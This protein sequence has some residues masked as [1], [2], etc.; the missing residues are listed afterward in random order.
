M[1]RS[2]FPLPS[3]SHLRTQI[4]N[5][6]IVIGG[7]GV[8]SVETYTCPVHRFKRNAG[9]IR[10]MMKLFFF[11]SLLNVA[12]PFVGGGSGSPCIQ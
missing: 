5:Y 2:Q 12:M 1:P 3:T 8:I 4:L 7:F 6:V 10:R 9:S 11:T